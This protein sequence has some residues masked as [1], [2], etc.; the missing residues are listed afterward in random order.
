MEEA[1]DDDEST[2]ALNLADFDLDAPTPRRA[3]APSAPAR[4][5]APAPPPAAMDDDDDDD[6][7]KTAAFNIDALGDLLAEPAPAPPARPGPAPAGPAPTRP[8]PHGAQR[9]A[10]RAM[11]PA[12]PA[13]PAPVDEDEDED[14][15]EGKTAAFSLDDMGDL[16]K[17][18][19]PPPARPVARSAA[20]PP[21]QVEEDEDDGEGKTAAFSLDDMGELMQ[22]APRAA[23]PAAAA[24]AEEFERTQ[25]VNLDDF[26]AQLPPPPS[27]GASRSRAPEPEPAPAPPTLTV[28]VGN[29]IGKSYTMSRDVSLVGRG[30]DADCVINDASASR[31]HFNVVRTSGGWK[32]VDLG[33]GNGTK[34]DG[35]R[36]QEIALTSGMK[37]ECG[38][39]TLEFTDPAQASEGGGAAEPGPYRDF[40]EDDGAEKTRMG[41]MAALEIDP[42]WEQRRARARQEQQQGFETVAEPVAELV[43]AKKK[44][45]TGKVLALVGGLVLLG[46]GGFV[47]A[48]KFGGLGIIFPKEATVETS[49][50]GGASGGGSGEGETPPGEVGATAGGA[51]AAGG[52]A[53]ADAKQKAKD[54]VLEG[55]AAYVER[56]WYEAKK[57]F[58]EALELN[59]KAERDSGVPVD[60]AVVLV[61]QQLD[62]WNTLVDAKKAA[63]EERFGDALELLKKIKVE[64]AYHKDA[65][66]LI[67]TVRDDLVAKSLGLAREA[68]DKGD[69]D[70]AKKAVAEALAASKDDP[71]ALAMQVAL[72]R[73]TAP[74]ADN[75]ETD[76][77][78]PAKRVQAVKVPK[79]D[80][81]PGFAKYAASDFM[82]AIDFFDG[83]TYGKASRRDKAKAKAV[84]GA[85]TKL[86][87]VL[88]A[89]RDALG[90]GKLDK[91]LDDL[92]LAKKYDQA[93]NGAFQSQINKDLG[94]TYAALAKDAFE[95]KN[96][97]SA[98]SYAKKAL[99][100]DPGN[101]DAS[102]M[103]GD[104]L[105]TARSWIEDA[106]AA[107]E[108]NPDKAMS[109]L[110][111]A[112]NVLPVDDEAYQTAYALLNKIGSKLDD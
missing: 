3:A 62:A 82:G 52:A 65:Q 80:L 22:E 61:D 63:S 64:T 19:A 83:I 110:S 58:K 109:L 11:P 67:P 99:A 14:D 100:V 5:R 86:D 87:T 45:G 105:K 29:D 30:M 57:F 13:R 34:V 35:H 40:E 23:A 55:E 95:K 41:D 17:E 33:S 59:P 46:G 68:E 78:D 27:R 44:G 73:A 47:A 56:R 2:Q 51:T 28:V 38:T 16:L 103:M 91:A 49:G 31:R 106:K 92:R 32:L 112:L 4:G 111:K 8:G 9:A 74:D 15:G 60:E 108:S 66:E 20:P 12:P 96:L 71:D 101:A 54:L 50:G 37:I 85:I 98:G 89:G 77:E 75:L 104:V 6:S 1:E 88:R 94:K 107:A 69:Y 53:A 79:I 102:A 84:A 42:D 24:A 90:A 72:E 97:T 21:A 26:E 10:A 25:A 48:D 70:A 81:K 93:V 7:E 76:D 36:V 18:T 39:T 43:A